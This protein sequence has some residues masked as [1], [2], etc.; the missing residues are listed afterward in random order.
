LATP[1]DA[2]A[3]GDAQASGD[4]QAKAAATYNAAADFFDD[5][6][7]TFWDRF[8][9][10]TIERLE[11]RGGER[12]LDVCCGSGASAIPAAVRVG[13]DGAVLGI[14][15]SERLLGLAR[16]KADARGL[17]NLELRIGDMLD[18]HVPEAHF[19]A[20][21]CVFGIFFVPDMAAAVRS[22]WRCV[23]PGGRL[24]ITTWGPRLFEPA[25]SIFW[26]SIREIRPELHQGFHPWDR[27]SDPAAVLALLRDGGVEH[28]E[29]VAEAGTHPIPS[30]EAW[31]SL[32][33]G[34]GYRG[35]LEQLD[36]GERER[37]CRMNLERVRAAGLREVEASVVYAVATKLA[38]PGDR[39]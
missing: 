28:A 20:V 12:V 39:G 4:A 21:A 23:R 5:A 27:I 34:S 33:L 25:N 26:S 11:L 2:Q 14:D 24:A 36:A 30:P 15:L 32:V 16:A 37:V 1:Q 35:T 6:S 18:L 17:R 13:A 22:L 31:W 29:A 8:G 38:A 3:K 9:R 10:R 19:D 7:N